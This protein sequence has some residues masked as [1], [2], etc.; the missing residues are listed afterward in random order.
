[1]STWAELDLGDVCRIFD[2]PH[3]TPTKTA[4]GPWFLSISS[5]VGGRLALE[6]SAHLSEADYERWSRRVTPEAGDVL[7][8]YETR[9]GDA[10]LMP[11]DVKACLGRRMGLL[12]PDRALVSPEFLLY[13]Y[14][15]PEF[16]RVIA[17]RAVHGATVD[18]IPLVDL[19]KW[20]IR[21]PPLGDQQAIVEVL[22]AL[23]D[24]VALN[25]GI[26]NTCLSLAGACYEDAEKGSAAEVLGDLAA[27][28]DG[29][30]ATPQKTPI[31]PWFLSISS[32][33]KGYL[34]LAESAH[35]SESE[36]PRWTRRVQPQGGDVLFSYETRLGD[37]ALMPQEVRGSLGRRMALLRSKTASVSGTLLLHAYLAPSFQEEIKRRTIHGATVDRLPLKEM[38]GWRIFLPA[39]G[40]RERLSAELDALHATV[41]QTANENRTLA[42][43]RDTLLPQLVTGKLRVKDAVRAVEEAV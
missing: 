2:G 43:L 37:A 31:G 13:A 8:S 17:E 18:R 34:D 20:P 40:E 3:A 21:I 5:L 27:L 29:P 11:P 26:R 9:L 22:G 25:E 41:M 14:M 23:D 7:F 42:D 6:E 30:H 33:K 15:G 12:R 1:M 10:A 4:V 19:P 16:Q 24:K 32:L 39:V 36:F 38:P 28:F 35:L